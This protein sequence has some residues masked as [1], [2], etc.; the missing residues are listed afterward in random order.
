MAATSSRLLTVGEISRRIGEP[1]HRVEYVIDARD[2]RPH[3]L[4]GNVRVFTDADLRY[5]AAEIRRI[6]EERE[7]SQ[8]A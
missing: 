3:G 2:V 5:I 1:L 6:D 8:S 7:G 4:A